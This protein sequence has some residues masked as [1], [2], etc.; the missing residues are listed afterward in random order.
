MGSSKRVVNNKKYIV[1]EDM[2]VTFVGP[3]VSIEGIDRVAFQMLW[4][5]TPTGTWSI[6]LSNDGVDFAISGAT[7]TIDPSGGAG[8]ISMIEV[9]TAAAFA[10]LNY[11]RTSGTGTL[12]SH[13]VG[14]SLS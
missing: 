3:T 6:G 11:I 13:V 14:K 7:A 2:S 12:Q 5:G 1:D 10:R 4:D 9:E 8:G